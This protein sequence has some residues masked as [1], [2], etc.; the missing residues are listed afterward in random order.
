MDMHINQERIGIINRSVIFF[1][2]AAII[3]ASC[4]LH[5]TFGGVR[6]DQSFDD[7]IAS[8]NLTGK[9]WRVIDIHSDRITV[10]KYKK[11][12]TLLWLQPGPLEK[13]DRVSF[14]ARNESL[15]G[16]NSDTVWHPVKIRI[17]GKSSF[18]FGI[19]FISALIVIIMCLRYIRFDRKS[20]SLLF[21]M[22]HG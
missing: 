7:M 4:M 19:S 16:L 8:G 18:K 9:F 14:V 11:K 20:Y 1:I 5:G 22:E 21:T 13:G 12:I 6:T 17:H 15:T 2:S 3:T 10:A